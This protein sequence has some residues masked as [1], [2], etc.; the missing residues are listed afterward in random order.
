MSEKIVP[1]C[2]KCDSVIFFKDKSNFIS[3][4][5]ARRLMVGCKL[6][7]EIKSYGDA[8]KKCPLIFGGKNE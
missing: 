1:F 5:E 3:F 2:W 8:C 4:A 7:E 6:H